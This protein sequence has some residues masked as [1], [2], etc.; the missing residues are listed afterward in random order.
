[1]LNGETLAYLLSVPQAATYEVGIVD[2]DEAIAFDLV[3]TDADGNELFN[4]IFG[5]INLELEPGDVLFQFEA[6]DNARLEFAV[7]GNIG[8]MTTD[9]DQPGV[10]PA[11]G[12]FYSDDV[13]EPVYATLSVADT[14]YPQQVTIYF[15]PGED[16]SFYVSA[17]GDD[18]GYIDKESSESDLLRF[19]THGGDFL[20]SAEPVGASLRTATHSLHRRPARRDRRSMSRSPTSSPPG[21]APSS[22][23]CRW[24]RSTTR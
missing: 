23:R 17:E 8:E 22:M 11:G 14:P 19:W 24:T 16:D 1:M 6:V 4:D 9:F 2:E 3:I 13:S 20:I 12:I 10:L 15:E 5:S 7:L 21:K 18:I